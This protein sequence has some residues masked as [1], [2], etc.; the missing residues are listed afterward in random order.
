MASKRRARRFVAFIDDD[1]LPA[2]PGWLQR[3]WRRISPIPAIAER[4]RRQVWRPG[5]MMPYAWR[6]LARRRVLSYSP[7]RLPYTYARFDEDVTPVASLHGPGSAGGVPWRWRP[8]CGR[9]CARE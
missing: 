3:R 4:L 2:G 1:D 7:L 9:G 6:G 5:E 8:A